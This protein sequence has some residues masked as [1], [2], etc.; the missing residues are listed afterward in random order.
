M[1]CYIIAEKSPEGKSGIDRGGKRDRARIRQAHP[2]AF[3]HRKRAYCLAVPS[4]TVA[5]TAWLV[6]ASMQSM[7]SMTPRAFST[8]PSSGTSSR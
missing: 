6:S 2:G 1:L 5:D 4:A 7:A 8:S 3:L